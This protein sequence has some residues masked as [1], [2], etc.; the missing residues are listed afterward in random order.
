VTTAF[1]R[2][3]A[4]AARADEA[5]ARGAPLGALHGFPLPTRTWSRPRGSGRRAGRRSTATS[6]PRSGSSLVMNT[7]SCRLHRSCRSM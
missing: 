4:D 5:M 7:S 2:A 3:M 6:F 1:D